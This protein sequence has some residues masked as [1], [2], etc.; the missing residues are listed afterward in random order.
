MTGEHDTPVLACTIDAIPKEQRPLHQA[1]AERLFAS[2]QEIRELA[3][4]Y[5][6][7]LLNETDLLQTVAAF[8]RYERLCCPFFHFKLEVEPNQGPIWFSIT[9]AVDV[10]EFLQS[11][12]LVQPGDVPVSE[13]V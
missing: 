2:A 10:K 1:N 9:G 11:E 4:G 12:G 6:W 7:R 3:T 8:I 5:V 13:E